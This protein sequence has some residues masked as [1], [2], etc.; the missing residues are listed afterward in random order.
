MKQSTTY[1]PLEQILKGPVMTEKA[2]QQ[3]ENGKQVMYVHPQASK[4]QI[5][6]AIKTFYGA[7][8]RVTIIKNPEKYRVRSKFGPTRKRLPRKKA[9]L[10]PV[11]GTFDVM[12]PLKKPAKQSSSS[13]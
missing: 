13:K 7:D 11:N 4:D 8:V 5:K 3:A 6:H 9:V 10:T 1:I 12:A 2:M